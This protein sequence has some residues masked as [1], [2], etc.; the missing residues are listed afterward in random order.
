MERDI[1]NWEDLD[2]CL[3]RAERLLQQPPGLPLRLIVIDSVAHIY[4]DAADFGSGRLTDMKLHNVSQ[5]VILKSIVH[6]IDLEI[7]HKSTCCCNRSR[8]RWVCRA[9]CAALQDGRSAEEVCRHVQDCS[10]GD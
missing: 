8:A 10:G 2:Q 9:D 1:A 3:E 4:R 7:L 5:K 6:R